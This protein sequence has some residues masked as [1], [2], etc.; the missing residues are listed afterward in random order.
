MTLYDQ[1]KKK[2]APLT[3]SLLGCLRTINEDKE[4][5]YPDSITIDMDINLDCIIRQKNQSVRLNEQDM[6]FLHK[7]LSKFFEDDTITMKQIKARLGI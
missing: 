5:G 3:N 6:R 7:L 1:L 2:K 4:V